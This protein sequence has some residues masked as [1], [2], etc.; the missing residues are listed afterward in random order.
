M[1]KHDG[2]DVAEP[3]CSRGTCRINDKEG[4]AGM[5]FSRFMNR[6]LPNKLKSFKIHPGKKEHPENLTEHSRRGRIFVF[7]SGKGGVGKTMITTSVGFYLGKL[8]KQVL[9]IDLDVGLRNLDIVSGVDGMVT[10][11]LSDVM[12]PRGIHWEDALVQRP[13]SHN[14]YILEAGQSYDESGFGQTRQFRDLVHQMARYFDYVLIDCPAGI[15]SGFLFAIS[16]ADE[17]VVVTTAENATLRGATQAC[18]RLEEAGISPVSCVLNMVDHEMVN[19]R[20]SA[21][22]EAVSNRL[23]VPVIAEIPYE[24][25]VRVL[26]HKGIPLSLWTQPSPSREGVRKLAEM[27]AGPVTDRIQGFSPERDLAIL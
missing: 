23:G 16:P 7:T 13:D 21:D 1:K 24:R 3:L 6:L 8:G 12:H 10:H 19:L 20:L 4:E 2:Y 17:A 27:M 15:G 22:A 14:V 5:D 25:L 26:G 18:I 9:I 11:N